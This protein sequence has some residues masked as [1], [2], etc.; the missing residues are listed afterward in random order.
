MNWIKLAKGFGAV[1]AGVAGA[2]FY[3]GSQRTWTTKKLRIEEM[4]VA[5]SME[6]EELEWRTK[7][8]QAMLDW[9]KLPPFS[10]P[11]DD[12]D[13]DKGDWKT[14]YSVADF[15]IAHQIDIHNLELTPKEVSEYRQQMRNIYMKD[16]LH[17]AGYRRP[18]PNWAKLM[19]VKV[20]Q[21][22]SR[23]IRF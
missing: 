20:L 5:V 21:W 8:Q 12:E 4:A 23:R 13:K 7:Q 22:M 1:T 15:L 14:F 9:I 3:R 18:N 10:D 17:S 2:A 16:N 11:A 19:K 6:L